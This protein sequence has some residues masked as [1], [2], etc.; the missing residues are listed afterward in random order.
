MPWLLCHISLLFFCFFSVDVIFL[1]F[2]T[3]N[4]ENKNRSH[5][6][7]FNGHCSANIVAISGYFYANLNVNFPS[8]VFQSSDKWI[9]FCGIFLFFMIFYG[10]PFSNGESINFNYIELFSIELYFGWCRTH[11]K[12]KRIKSLSKISFDILCD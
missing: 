6:N 9:V 5:T 10:G 4:R 1:R 11:T 12:K 7:S 8:Y 2:T 3:C